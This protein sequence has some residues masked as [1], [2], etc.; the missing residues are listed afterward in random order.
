MYDSINFNTRLTNTLRD[1]G[2]LQIGVFDGNISTPLDNA[3]IKI[4]S[5]AD[6]ANIIDQEISNISGQSPIVN[7]P[8]PSI[9]Y[10]LDFESQNQPFS[11][12]DVVVTADGFRPTLIQ[13]VQ[14]FPHTIATQNIYMQPGS[15]SDSM[16]IITINKPTLWGSFPPKIVEDSVNELPESSGYVVLPEVVIPEFIIVHDGVPTDT[17]AQNYWVSFTDYIKNVASCEIYSTWPEE[18]IKANI[19][20][21]ISFTLNRVYTEWYRAKG[22]DFTITSSTAYDHAFNFGRNIFKEI[23]TIVDNIFNQFVTKPDI[24]QPL[25]TQ[26]CDGKRVSCPNWMTQWGSKQLGDQ[27]YNA[28][29]ILKSYYGQEIFLMNAKKVEGIPLS[30]QGTSLQMG[31]TGEQVRTIQEQLNAIS[32]NYPAIKKVRVDGI[33]GDETRIAV[34]T[35]QDIFRL[36]STGIVDFATWY[37]ISDIYVAVLRL[38]ELA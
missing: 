28:I 13:G 38:A 11:D 21:I 7:L 8:S 18:T 32:N 10:S 6:N 35:F 25:F 27:G 33:Y 29:D 26:Y 20:A 1:E 17:S 30:F 19:L 14:I 23:S 2:Q 4:I 3:N 15:L 22:Y 16:N 34:E 12:Y 9:D 5:K 24:R 31:S 37:R 36:P